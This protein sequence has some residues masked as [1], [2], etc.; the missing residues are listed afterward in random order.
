MQLFMKMRELTSQ[1][2]SLSHQEYQ[3]IL[4]TFSVGR[5]LTYRWHAYQ[6]VRIR[7]STPIINVLGV[8]IQTQ[9]SLAVCTTRIKTTKGDYTLVTTDPLQQSRTCLGIKNWL[10]IVVTALQLS[11]QQQI[12]PTGN[13]NTTGSHRY[14][15]YHYLFSKT[16]VYDPKTATA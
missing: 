16:K 6:D 15:L 10:D 14:N 2:K 9:D 8:P 11:D 12:L 13:L 4:D 1:V 5:L 3:R 7:S